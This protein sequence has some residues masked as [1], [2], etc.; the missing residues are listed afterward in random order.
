M[1]RVF[2]SLNHKPEKYDVAISIYSEQGRLVEE[3]EYR[4]VKQVVLKAREVRVS[5]QLASNPIVLIAELDNPSIEV[6]GE[7]ILSIGEKA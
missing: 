7:D 2:I 6:V 3:R 5:A 4:G 1:A